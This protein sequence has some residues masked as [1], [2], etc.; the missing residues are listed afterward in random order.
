[1]VAHR[2]NRKTINE[3]RYIR[4]SI[5]LD[6]ITQPN[7]NT[8][9]HLLSAPEPPNVSMN[10]EQLNN[11]INSILSSVPNQIPSISAAE[12]E[13]DSVQYLLPVDLLVSVNKKSN[14]K[15]IEAAIPSS[16]AMYPQQILATPPSIAPISASPSFISASPSFS[17]SF[18]AFSHQTKSTLNP[19]AASFT[20]SVAT[21]PSMDAIAEEYP[22]EGSTEYIDPWC[23]LDDMQ[24]HKMKKELAPITPSQ[25]YSNLHTFKAFKPRKHV[26]RYNDYHHQR[27]YNKNWR[28]SRKPVHLFQKSELSQPRLL[29]EFVEHVTLQNREECQPDTVLTKTWKLKNVGSTPWGFDVELVYCKG[30]E[31]LSLYD[32]YPVINAQS[33]QEVEISAT[34]KTA[35]KAGRYCTYFRLQKKGKYFGPRVWCDIIVS[36]NGMDKRGNCGCVGTEEIGEDLMKPKANKWRMRKQ[37]GVVSCKV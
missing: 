10:N 6:I 31:S 37:N 22:N 32:R 25:K 3:M 23:A 11:I 18:P 30:D 24:S 15:K 33:G 36:S 26:H 5:Y 21:K 27:P 29:A 28:N 19:S 7:K 2:T 14:V 35:K 16:F 1:M 20:P 17:P 34:I 9:R 13:A 12:N 4:S 8:Q